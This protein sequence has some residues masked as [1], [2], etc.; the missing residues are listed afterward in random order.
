MQT[1]FL[2]R[3]ASLFLVLIIFGCASSSEVKKREAKPFEP[4]AEDKAIISAG[5]K[6]AEE[7][8]L[9]LRW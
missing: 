4:S 1:I 5:I 7:L 3:I 9:R 6:K 2:L 8:G